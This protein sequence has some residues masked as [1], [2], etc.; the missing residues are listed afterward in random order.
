VLDLSGPALSADP[1]SVALVAGAARLVETVLGLRI[2]ER[3]AALRERYERRVGGAHG[4]ADALVSPAGRVLGSSR[5]GWLGEV[6]RIPPGGGE[7]SLAG[8]STVWAEPVGDRDAYLLFSEAP[9]S[10]VREHRPRLTGLGRDRL[11]LEVGDATHTLS[12][13]HSEILV[14]LA[15]RPR[16][17][18]AEQLA[19]ELYG[20]FGKPV[21][22]RAEMS[23][24]RGLLGEHL[25]RMPYR[26]AE[27]PHADFTGLVK[28][29][30]TEPLA[31]VVRDY[32]GALLPRSEVPGVVEIREWIDESVR[33]AVLASE[34][35]D[36]LVAWLQSASGADDLVACRTL[37]ELLP[38]DHPE[39]PFALSR[40]RRLTGATR[41]GRSAAARGPADNVG[42]HEHE[43]RTRVG[44]AATRGDPR[45]ADAARGLSLT[46]PH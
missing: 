3:H 5:A 40:L 17:L 8:G 29:I 13:R 46:Q 21:S 1:H 23:R 31:D 22:T 10:P 27:T 26:L 42:G 39:R 9:A 11:L 7:V 38:A 43:R 6:V 24:L 34:D 28:R 4:G 19:F 20:D 45:P 35:A 18:S 41:F 16:G 44:P 33:G 12:P 14:L 37:A 32:P 30:G 2:A 25:L 36:A 15:T